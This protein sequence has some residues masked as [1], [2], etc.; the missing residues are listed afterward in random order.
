MEHVRANPEQGLFNRIL[1]V[2]QNGLPFPGR[3]QRYLKTA[4][5]SIGVIWLLVILYL[6]VA[7]TSYSS[8]TTLILP[9]SGVG[10]SIN[11]ETIGQASTASSSA[12]SSSSLSPTENYKRLLMS[13]VVLDRAADIADEDEG[14]FPRPTIR[15][16]DQTN[17]IG[18]NVAGDTREHARR[19]ATALREAFLVELARL[20]ADEAERREEAD[21]SRL[22][23]LEAKVREAQ[24]ALLQFQGET[25]LVSMDQFNGRVAAFDALR[26]RE[27]D[28]RTAT[29][30]T[31]AA[32]SRL[33]SSL[34]ISRGDARRA[35][36]LGAD[37][38]FQT[39][40]DRYANLTAQR[41]EAS[42]TLGSRHST[43]EE[44]TAETDSLRESLSQRGRAL[45]GLSGTQIMRFADLAVSDVR[46][47]LMQS[48]LL[49]DSEAA[50]ES[51]ALAEIRAQLQEQS[52]TSAQLV[53]KAS[54][55]ADL[56]RDLRV[57]E[58]VF[59]S[60]LAQLDTNQSDPFASYPLVQT[61]E[62]PSLP[63][64][65]SSPKLLF[66][67]GGGLL[68]T[69]LTLIGFILLWSRQQ[70]IRKILPSG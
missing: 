68:A 44:L 70:V 8:R 24:R 33:A 14:D 65:P 40:L 13:D 19:R 25:G 60:A 67:L 15:L 50:G 32:T 36:L 43:I 29:R 26:D 34:Q 18:V 56:T 63:S 51:A 9:G 54:E 49:A 2:A 27:R 38:E 61:L 17:L 3:T 59:S 64:R 30:R 16:V 42:G 41:A 22:D 7:P 58:A 11:L 1:W 48:T 37:P 20:R 46:A 52:A 31:Q 35:M 39:L 55:L 5:P 28:A 57:A 47:G 62:E 66:V 23:G 21:R 69:F 53:E 12:F 4:L 10:S 6:I 45:T